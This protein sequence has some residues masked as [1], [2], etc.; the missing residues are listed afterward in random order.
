MSVGRGGGAKYFFGGGRN[1]HQD[2]LYLLIL[3]WVVF[4]LV[5]FFGSSFFLLLWFQFVCFCVCFLAVVLCEVVPAHC[6]LFSSCLGF[7][8]GCFCSSLFSFG[9]HLVARNM[10]RSPKWRPIIAAQW[11]PRKSILQGKI[12][13]YLR[14]V[15][16]VGKRGYGNRLPI[17][18]RTPIRKFSIDCLNAS[19]TNEETQRQVTRH[20]RESRRKA[21]TEFQYRPRIVD[22]D[23]DCGPRFCGPR[24][25]DSYSSQGLTTSHDI[26][27]LRITFVSIKS[28]TVKF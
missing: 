14:I 27:C 16:G 10:I 25:R 22:T 3:V 8:S 9:S 7:A 28:C 13:F 2:F 4:E 26:N 5:S 21:D 6:L 17:D 20:C 1:A 12:K 23:I 15:N 19:K 11:S 18:D 24:F